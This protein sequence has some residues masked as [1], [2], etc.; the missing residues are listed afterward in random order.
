MERE[1]ATAMTAVAARGAA[2][3]YRFRQVGTDARP[4]GFRSNVAAALMLAVLFLGAAVVPALAQGKELI[5][6]MHMEPPEI[7]PLRYTSTPGDT[8]AWL[9]YNTLFRYTSEG[10]I[11]GDLAKEWEFLDD[12]TLRVRLHEGVTFHDGKPLTAEDVA[13]TIRY[14]QDPANGARL[15]GQL[16]SIKSI[17]V[18]DDHTVVFHLDRPDAP[19]LHH[20]SLVYAA[21]VPSHHVGAGRD[22]DL[23]P[24]G[25]GPFRLVERVPGVRTVLE[26]YDGYFEPGVPYVDRIVFI[27]LPDDG[28]RTT[29][30]RTGAIHV[31]DYVPWQ[32]MAMLDMDPNVKLL[33][34]EAITTGFTYNVSRPP[35]DNMLVRRALSHA[36]DREAMLAVAF[37]G[38]GTIT[39]GGVYMPGTLGYDPS[40]QGTYEYN[41]QRARELLAE[42]GYPNGFPVRILTSSTH[43]FMMRMGEIALQNL[44]DIGIDAALDLQEWAVVAERRVT[45][46]YDIMV[47]SIF[48]DEA[49]P[50]VLST[51]FGPTGSFYQTA[52]GFQDD[53][54]DR[55][56]ELGRQT[57]DRDE[58]RRIYQ[59][60]DRRIVELAPVTGVVYRAQGMAMRRE[61]EGIAF[62]P[63]N[64][65]LYGVTLR[66]VGIADR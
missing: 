50:D 42:A 12:V 8:I 25:S 3:G 15:Q 10:E 31:S 48:T 59:A 1:V 23:E 24:L 46:D 37:E 36:F 44:R 14:I 38:Y 62:I 41:P 20:L 53:E 64:W 61:V 32:D 21:I 40:L 65:Y 7:E 63:G 2:R 5:F 43:G 51:F 11:V 45:G 35:L 4:G 9:M 29:A 30:L 60:L 13:V 39:T 55:L 54:I 16:S 17:T 28:T 66:Y 47:A 58:R 22:L 56:L 34:T 6:G 19:L 18:E 57:H 52:V 26:R 49:E 27:P 33:V